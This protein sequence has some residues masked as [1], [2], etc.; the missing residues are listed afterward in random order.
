M[1]TTGKRRFH[2][3]DGPRRKFKMLKQM[4]TLEWTKNW[5]L[6]RQNRRYHTNRHWHVHKFTCFRSLISVRF[7][8]CFL[9]FRASCVD[10]RDPC[11]DVLNVRTP[12]NWNGNN[13]SVTLTSIAHKSHVSRII[14]IHFCLRSD[15]FNGFSHV[16]VHCQH[17][18]NC[19]VRI[20]ISMLAAQTSGSISNN[21]ET[22]KNT[23]N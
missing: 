22:N 1:K 14:F 8:V 19:R 11:E 17:T 4:L 12:E 6:C 7:I 18:W 21:A 3:C 20:S 9:V 23:K 13:S 15:I 16:C 2:R 5:W 10:G